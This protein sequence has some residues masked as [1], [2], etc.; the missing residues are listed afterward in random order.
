MPSVATPPIQ[1]TEEE[2]RHYHDEGW[3]LVRGLIPR[4][5]LEGPRRAMLALETG[6]HD[7]PEE[8]C[9]YID[10]AAV[11]DAKGN[12]MPGGLQR[13]AK[14]S[15]EFAAVCDHPR[16]VAAMS[17]LLGGQVT[18]FTEQAA[19]KTRLIT[20]EQGGKSFYHQDSSYWKLDPKL[21]CNC[22]IPF[23]EVGRDAIALAIMPRTHRDWT[24]LEHETYFDDPAYFGAR[25]TQPFPRLR[26]PMSKIDFSREVL[27]PMSPGDGLFFTNFTWHRS[28]PNYTGESK[29]FYAVAY[30]L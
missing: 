22:W 8:H 16:L 9:H 14:R 17:Q 4:A 20:T 7:W 12:K 25:A 24:I 10:P 13:P 15:P 26:I 11:R 28:E 2:L 21:G 3:L 27:V 5:L 18:L 19:I 1:L 6:E 30:R 29:C 23:D